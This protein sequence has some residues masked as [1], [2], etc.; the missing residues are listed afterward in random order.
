MFGNQGQQYNDPLTDAVIKASGDYVQSL[1]SGNKISQFDGTELYNI[2]KQNVQNMVNELNGQFHNQG[3]VPFQAVGNTVAGYCNRIWQ[4]MSMSANRQPQQTFQ[5]QTN[6][7]PQ[8]TFQQSGFSSGGQ[9]SRFQQTNRMP[10][11]LPSL[12]DKKT[13]R[14]NTQVF[15]KELEKP[16]PSGIALVESNLTPHRYTFESMTEATQLSTKCGDISIVDVQNQYLISD[17]HTDSYI[18]TKAVCYVPEATV[19]QVV[20]NFVDTNPSCCVG[21]YILDL[22]YS[23]FVLKQVSSQQ[24]STIDLTPLHAAQRI[25]VP[26]G[27]TVKRVLQSIEER[28]MSVAKIISNLLIKEFNDKLKRYVRT[29]DEIDVVIEINELDDIRDLADMRDERFGGVQYHRNYEETIFQCFKESVE[30]IVTDKTKVGYYN[31]GDIIKHLRVH[32]DFVLRHNGFCERYMDID[33]PE[34]IKIVG[35]EYTAFAN[36]GSIVVTNFIPKDLEEDLVNSV[37][38]IKNHVNPLDALLSKFWYKADQSRS[39]SKTI[40]MREGTHSFVV[41]NGMTMGGTQ[42]IFADK[43]DID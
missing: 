31:T 14:D 38:L 34:H 15:V 16:T 36:N 41:K 37:M 23:R 35:S 25:N 21:A 13:S 39:L 24:C 2:L 1:V 10:E 43:L 18:Y 42:F 33:N 9:Q 11:G 32:P 28:N 12:N 4:Q 20:D 19:K 17:E 7:Q 3:S 27:V 29:D 8:N 26:V 6:F 5:P 22:D 30:S 40:W